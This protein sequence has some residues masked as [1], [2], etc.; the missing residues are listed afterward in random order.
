MANPLRTFLVFPFLD[1]KTHNPSYQKEPEPRL[2]APAARTLARAAAP[3]RVSSN[4]RESG[5]NLA[6]SGGSAG[7]MASPAPSWTRLDPQQERDVR[8]LI[9]LVSGV[10]DEADPNFQLA[11]HFAW[12]NFRCGRGTRDGRVSGEV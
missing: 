12:S 7:G 9:R 3:L 11:L 6:E 1:G 5:R 8:E 10:Q 4:S 2:K